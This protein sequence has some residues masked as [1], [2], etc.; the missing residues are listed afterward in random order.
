MID[1]KAKHVREAPSAVLPIDAAR[2]EEETL[3][4]KSERGSAGDEYLT[5]ERVTQFFPTGTVNLMSS[6]EL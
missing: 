3:Q 4:R 5:R 2:R 6:F 1:P